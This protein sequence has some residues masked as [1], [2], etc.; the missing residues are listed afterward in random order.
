[1][2]FWQLIVLGAGLAY[3]ASVVRDIAKY[4]VMATETATKR[5]LEMADEIKQLRYEI[6]QLQQSS[7]YD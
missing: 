2:T 4:L 1:M 6:K 7:R 5:Q 3:I